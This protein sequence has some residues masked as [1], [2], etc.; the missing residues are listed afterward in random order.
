MGVFVVEL[1]VAVSQLVNAEV[2]DF[3]HESVVDDAVR[4]F[5]AS[6]RFNV[7][8]VQVRHSLDTSTTRQTRIADCVPR[9]T[10]SH[11]RKCEICAPTV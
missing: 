1:I 10:A 2:G 6:V 11:N 9:Q 7:G 3:E 5:Q 4:A 8:T